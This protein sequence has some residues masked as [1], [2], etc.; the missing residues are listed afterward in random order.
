M[1]CCFVQ[2]MIEMITVET[3][4]DNEVRFLYN[5]KTKKKEILV[6]LFFCCCTFIIF[7]FF[8]FRRTSTDSKV[9]TSNIQFKLVVIEILIV[10]VIVAKLISIVIFYPIQNNRIFFAFLDKI[11]QLNENINK[12]LC[13]SCSFFSLCIKISCY[14]CLTFVVYGRDRR[15]TMHTHTHT[16]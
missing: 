16:Q 11:N 1:S 14:I 12:N 5:Y 15:K 3:T 7:A 6:F 9:E 10:L 13:F 8:V 2:V 4:I